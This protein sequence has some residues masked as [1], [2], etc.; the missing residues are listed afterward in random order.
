MTG[1]LL[2]L[3]RNGDGETGPDLTD[4]TLPDLQSLMI[5]LG[6]VGN[7]R[8]SPSDSIWSKED[9]TVVIVVIGADNTRHGVCALRKMF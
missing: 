6:N 2:S 3:K 1:T 8:S 5:T 4:L 7:P 9:V